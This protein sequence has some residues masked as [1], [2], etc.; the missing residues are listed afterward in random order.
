[1]SENS[2]LPVI[3]NKCSRKWAILFKERIL[4]RLNDTSQ[5]CEKFV[6]QETLSAALLYYKMHKYN[7][8]LISLA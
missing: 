6:V 3:L 2:E 4:V 7:D 8:G 5:S 1:M